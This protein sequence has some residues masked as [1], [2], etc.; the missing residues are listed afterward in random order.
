[1]HEGT[2]AEALRK[3][4][5]SAPRSVSSAAP[6]PGIPVHA[7]LPRDRLSLVGLTAATFFIVSGGPFG[8][9]EIVLGQGYGG[10]AA[11]LLVVPV[12]WSLPMALLVG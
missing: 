1:M 12:L 6:T 7:P 5:R 10:A 2:R 4:S 8:L 9:E 11:L 3:V